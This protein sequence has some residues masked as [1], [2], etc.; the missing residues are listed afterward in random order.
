M[1][2]YYTSRMAEY[3]P[4]KET[5]GKGLVAVLIAGA[6]LTTSCA[7]SG[8]DYNKL[9]QETIEHESGDKPDRPKS[10]GKGSN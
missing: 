7:T 10:K 6:L 8:I 3:L 5:V 2:N 9:M 1:E 4:S